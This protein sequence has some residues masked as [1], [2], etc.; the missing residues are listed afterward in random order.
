[1]NEKELERVMLLGL[2]TVGE[3]AKYI[4]LMR[5]NHNE[6]QVLAEIKKMY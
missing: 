1:M 5:T 4:Q 3:V 6:I 2:K